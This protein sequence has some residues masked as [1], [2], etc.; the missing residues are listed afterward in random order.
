M[1]GEG[2]SRTTLT[3]NFG[4]SRQ[5]AIVAIRQEADRL[6][7]KSERLRALA[8]AAEDWEVGSPQEIA[9]WSM[10]YDSVRR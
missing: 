2:A 4:G 8:R 10:F 6:D 7:E 3:G 1:T 9:L 5:A